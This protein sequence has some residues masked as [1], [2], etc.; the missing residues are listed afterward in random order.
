[1]IDFL[2]T[3]PVFT[4][5]I[6]LG[7]G[8]LLGRLRIG[9]VS[10]GP[11]AGAL[12]VSL[13]FG[14]FGFK[15][16]EG[17]QSVGFALFIFAVG[18]Q[19]GPRFFEVLKTQGLQYLALALFVAGTGGAIAIAAG[20]LLDLPFGGTAGLL[21]G[22][23]TTTPTLAA[24]QDAVRSGIVAL[25]EG[26][27]ADSVLATIASSYAITY[28]VGLLGIIATIR[29]LP[30]VVG[31]D[32]AAE[33]AKMEEA[34]KPQRGGQLQARA[35][36]VTRPEACEPTVRMIRARFW[37]AM[38]VTKLLR[39][40]EWVRLGD[41]EHLQLGDELH[42]YGDSS[43]FRGGVEELGEEIP[44]SPEIDMSADYTHVVIARRGAVGKTIAELNL[45]RNHGLVVTEVRRDGV[46]LPLSSH[47]RLQRS[48][49]LSVAGPKPGLREMQEVLGP[50]ESGIAET[51]MATF[52]FGIALGALIG[53]FAINVG[54]VPIGLGMAGGLLGSG[55]FVGWFNAIRPTFG[56]F[57]EAARWILMEFGLMI[58]IVGVGL[59]AGGQIVATFA[60]AGPALVLAAILVVAG[61]A[62]LGYVFGRKVLRLHP[63]LLLGA[64]TGAMTSAAAMAL[65]NREA[66]SAIP[67]LGYTGTYAFANVILTV[68]GTL[69]MFV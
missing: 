9:P 33:A 44:V 57:P 39:N 21:A 15:V 13:V 50:V 43:F 24:A 64:L 20:R 12:L 42:A 35:Y 3:N 14:Q 56:R 55:I 2:R 66:K 1:M 19:A 63:V 58:F 23:M 7:G 22:A 25:P 26:A 5:F 41:D 38:S 27:S 69:I 8:Y 51:D 59:Q 68:A 10:L 40:G 17:A 45:A 47:L 60:K 28:I 46:R 29:M 11:V 36:R 52:A 65:V 67:A 48:D 49:V 34:G 62:L 4:L 61:P 54:G 6:I 31:V 37:D 53:V 32:L 18:Y 30:R 16:S